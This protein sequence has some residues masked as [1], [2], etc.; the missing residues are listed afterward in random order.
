MENEPPTP[1]VYAQI[2]EKL[3]EL[4]DAGEGIDADTLKVALEE[5]LAA[6]KESGEFD[7]A[8]GAQGPK[9]DKGDAGPAYTLTSAD[10][11]SIASAVKASLA[12]E[13][14]TFELED[15]GTVT[16]AVYVG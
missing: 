6:A 11:S 15:G 3:N 2:M 4:A 5:A 8:D 16:K 1:D 7:G 13:T 14:W 9:G 10:K 12:K